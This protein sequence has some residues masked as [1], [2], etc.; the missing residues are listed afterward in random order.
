MKKIFQI[1]LFF[2]L[3]VNCISVLLTATISNSS[4]KSISL[5]GFGQDKFYFVDNSQP[6]GFQL[7]KDP[8]DS[9]NN[10][11]VLKFTIRPK[12]CIGYDCDHQSVRTAVAQLPNAVQPKEAWYGWDM[13]FP[14]NFPI[15][16]EQVNGFYSFINWKDNIDC[17]SGLTNDTYLGHTTLNWVRHRPTGKS[18]HDIEGDCKQIYNV[19]IAEIKDLKGSWRRFEL[20]VRWSKK[21]DGR[22]QLYLDNKKVLDYVGSTCVTNCQKMNFQLIGNYLCC[23]PNTKTVLESTVYY[24]FIS[25]AKSRDKL[26]W[27]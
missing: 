13:Y 25:R 22:Y 26:K 21:D 8:L 6:K 16:S 20:F 4:E 12:S 10:Q 17:G 9:L 18:F 23:T 15:G 3:I 14:E 5:S 7:V 2:S 19:P 24:R 27:E 11:H 1:K